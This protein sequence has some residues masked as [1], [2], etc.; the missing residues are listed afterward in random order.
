MHPGT[1][2]DLIGVGIGAPLYAW[3]RLR[4]RG[5]PGA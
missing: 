1:I 2:T 3:Q 5:A 4:A